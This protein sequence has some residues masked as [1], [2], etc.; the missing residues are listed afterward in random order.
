ME[1]REITRIEVPYPDTEALQLKISVGACRLKVTPM[2]A[3]AADTGTSAGAAHGDT[4]VTGTYDDPSGGLASKV[5]DEGPGMVKITQQSGISALKAP[6][7]GAPRMELAVNTARPFA[8]IV[9]TGASETAFDLG[10]L[11]LTKLVFK[12][13]AGKCDFDFSAPNPVEMDFMDIDAGAVTL[14]MRNLANANFTKMT[15]DG[16]AATYD[17]EFGGKLQRDA[18]VRMNTG[19][20]TLRVAVPASTAARVT[21]GSVL[22]SLD[23]GDGLTKMEGA[24]LTEAAMTGS[25]P[26]ISIAASMAV[27]VLKLAVI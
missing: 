7:S 27:G 14:A 21:P 23:I 8:L 5:V 19:V 25:G 18:E 17:F 10:G 13:A 16:A 22:G 26:V 2:A 11:P 24:F 4:W 12:Q 6:F 20:S 1:T 9:E 3:P 15:L